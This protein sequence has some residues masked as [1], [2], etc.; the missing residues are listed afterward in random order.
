MRKRLATERLG[1]THRFEIIT[2]SDAKTFYLTCGVYPDGRLGEVFL[3]AGKEGSLIAGALD[4]HAISISI[5]LQYGVPLKAYTSKMR[6]TQFEPSGL[7]PEAPEGLLKHIG[8]SSFFAKS[9]FDYMA[10]YLN[11]K[12]PD[13]MLSTESYTALHCGAL[14]EE[15][16]AKGKKRI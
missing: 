5:G 1:L 7:V 9:P 13:G 12:F 3:N 11:W 16:D 10:A 14:K 15:K 6:F 4:G 2:E 8:A